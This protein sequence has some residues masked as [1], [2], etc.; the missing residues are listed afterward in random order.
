[1]SERF[2]SASAPRIGGIA[3]YGRKSK[4]EMVTAFRR[5]YAQ[6]ADEARRALALTDDEI[7]V[8]TYIGSYVQRNKEVV[9]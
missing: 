1:M 6:Q 2:T 9:S 8:E 4:P 3:E 5:Y 7:V